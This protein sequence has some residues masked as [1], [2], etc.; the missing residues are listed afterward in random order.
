LRP[1]PGGTLTKWLI[2]QLRDSGYRSVT[3]ACFKPLD[4]IIYVFGDRKVG[5]PII[6][7]LFW[8]GERKEWTQAGMLERS[9]NAV[10]FDELYETIKSIACDTVKFK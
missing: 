6:F 5:S 10:T 9:H 7:S 8:D 3:L 1:K 2:T 4:P